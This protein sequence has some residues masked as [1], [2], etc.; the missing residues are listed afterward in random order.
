M[1]LP[2]CLDLAPKL[3]RD[4]NI[5][6]MGLGE[7]T[8]EVLLETKTVVGRSPQVVVFFGEILFPVDRLLD[9]IKDGNI[10]EID[11]AR[12]EI[13]DE[14][15]WLLDVMKNLVGVGLCDQA[16]ILGSLLTGN[17]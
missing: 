16:T 8:Q 15:F 6:L 14:G 11:T 7:R 1:N 5:E 12:N 13:G 2:S 17:L 9:L 3:L 4:V 10:K